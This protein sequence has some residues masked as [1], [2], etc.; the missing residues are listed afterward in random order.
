MVSR[1]LPTGLRELPWA[2]LAFQYSQRLEYYRDEHSDG[3]VSG[4][5]VS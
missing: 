5:A 1:D 2:S 4:H 3:G